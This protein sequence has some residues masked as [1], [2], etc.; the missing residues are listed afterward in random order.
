MANGPLRPS[1]IQLPVFGI[2]GNGETACGINNA[3]HVGVAALVPPTTYQQGVPPHAEAAIKLSSTQTPV[4]W[5]SVCGNV[6][7]AA[8]TAHDIRDAVLTVRPGLISARP[9]NPILPR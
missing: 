2:G 4:I 1:C 8:L 3:A 5:V 9:A 7:S 6:G